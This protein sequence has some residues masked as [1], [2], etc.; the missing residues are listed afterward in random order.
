[1]DRARELLAERPRLAL[2][3][4]RW[5]GAVRV[6]DRAAPGR[7][8]RIEELLR[9]AGERA[10]EDLRALDAPHRPRHLDPHAPVALLELL[11]EEVR[12][13]RADPDLLVLVGVEA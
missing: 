9:R 3:A 7:V 5:R 13:I 4:K 11:P 12:P 10:R 1:L 6:E 2:I 8:A